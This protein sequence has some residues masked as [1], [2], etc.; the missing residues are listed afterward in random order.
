[1]EALFGEGGDGEDAGAEQGA[2][3]A[4]AEAFF[5]E[6][7]GR[8]SSRGLGPRRG[9]GESADAEQVASQPVAAVEGE[10]SDEAV[11]FSSLGC[12]APTIE[13]VRMGITL[14]DP[15]SPLRFSTGTAA[16][17]STRSHLYHGPSGVY[18]RFNLGELALAS[19]FWRTDGSDHLEARLQTL[20][21]YPSDPADRTKL[22]PGGPF[23][24]A[25]I[26]M[27]NHAAINPFLPPSTPKGPVV[28]LPNGAQIQDRTP[29]SFTGVT[30]VDSH[31][32]YCGFNGACSATAAGPY[33]Q[34]ELAKNGIVS[35]SVSTNGANLLNLLLT[36][37]ADYV[38][39]ALDQLKRL[40][41]T[42]F[43]DRLDFTRAALVGHSRGGDAVVKALLAN[44]ARTA[45]RHG[46]KAVVS[47][48]PTD[49]TGTWPPAQRLAVSV[50]TNAHYLVLYGSHDA[51][52]FGG[53]DGARGGTGTGFRHYDRSN[54][55]RAMVF[56]H[57]AN[58]NQFNREWASEV[59]DHPDTTGS[60]VISRTAQETIAKEYVGGWLRYVLNH[61]WSQ[62]GFFN[63]RRDNSAHVA[64]SLMWKFGRNLNTI[65]RFDVLTATTNTMGG[66][67]TQP[68]YVTKV[69][70]SNE[71]PPDPAASGAQLPTFPHQDHVA[72]AQPITGTRG[73]FRQ[74]IPPAKKNFSRFNLLTFRCTKKYPI[75]DARAPALDAAAAAAITAA[76]LPQI[77]ITIED[78]FSRRATVDAAALLSANPRVRRPNFRAG[79]DFEAGVRRNLTKITMETW[80][81]PLSR[82]R[83]VNLTSVRAVEFDFDAAAGQPIYVD[84]ISL[85]RL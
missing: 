63:G 52:V 70:I 85:I 12:L 19:P 80:Q 16:R 76:A 41:P 23:P 44:R 51:D 11:T 54:T 28:T 81:V 84:T 69:V 68:S 43:D 45:N 5:A 42:R 56:V 6:L 21:V 72:K 62:A 58:H 7:I 47:I 3:E 25:V 17:A 61:E 14:D 40:A 29:T 33:L 65:D 66:A 39:A 73:P 20:I 4:A 35:I 30:S 50:G 18:Y 48:A 46:I 31:L 37:R 10:A 57:G 53:G 71:D 27:G 67:V 36:T 8:P 59:L 34:E 32:G 78:T 83:G 15:S 38:L 13:W 82:F 79:D 24:V 49:F 77:N 60:G 9:S 55:H 1:M 64:C 2:S 26:V 75:L 22:A 74:T